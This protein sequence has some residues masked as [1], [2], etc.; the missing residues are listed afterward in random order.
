MKLYRVIVIALLYSQ[1]SLQAMK[2]PKN[3]F[4]L[5]S[6]HKKFC[7]KETEPVRTVH[8]DF[9]LMI[10]IMQ[11]NVSMLE[12]YINNGHKVYDN[13]KSPLIAATHKGNKDMVQKLLPFY[14]DSSALSCALMAAA[15]HGKREIASLLLAHGAN[16]RE[17]DNRALL[18]AIQNNHLPVVELLLQNGACLY[19]AL[20]WAQEMRKQEIIEW[21]K[22]R[23]IT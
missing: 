8:G 15:L 18:Y 22:Q 2:R 6:S 14:T 23:A 21:L 7:F 16:A 11:G 5:G 20:L 19:K 12:S 1:H 13:D 17:H 3:N 9:Y 10:P 4:S